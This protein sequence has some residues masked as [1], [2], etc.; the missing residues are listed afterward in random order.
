MGSEGLVMTSQ[1]LWDE[2]NAL[3]AKLKP[4]WEG[5]RAHIVAQ[6]VVAFD[7]TRWEVLTEGSASKNSWTMW[8]LSTW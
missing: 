3:A 5:L 8:Q 1:T 4:A 7:E 6:A 2:V